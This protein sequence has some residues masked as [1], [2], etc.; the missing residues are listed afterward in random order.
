[1][2]CH[3]YGELCLRMAITSQ[4]AQGI[5]PGPEIHLCS[6]FNKKYECQ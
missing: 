6:N 1:M 2:F 4:A 3:R 5:N